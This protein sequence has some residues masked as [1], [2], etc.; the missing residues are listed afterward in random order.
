MFEIEA[1]ARI[2]IHKLK[3]LHTLHIHT[4][5]SYC[6][7]SLWHS[8]CYSISSNYTSS[9]SSPVKR[10]SCPSLGAIVTRASRQPVCWRT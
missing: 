8:L 1:S 9:S 2:H 5:Y 3:L 7:F 4:C 6:Y 10:Y